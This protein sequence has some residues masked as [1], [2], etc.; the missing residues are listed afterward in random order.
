MQTLHMFNHKVN[1]TNQ[2]EPHGYRW[3]A[4]LPKWN[5]RPYS[6]DKNYQNMKIGNRLMQILI[7]YIS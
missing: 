2:L 3:G 4:L 6:I 7:H 5:A 1:S